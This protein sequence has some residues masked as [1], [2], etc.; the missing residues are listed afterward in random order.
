V[1]IA[2]KLSAY[3][4]GYLHRLPGG[5]GRTS[6]RVA[7]NLHKATVGL[8]VLALML[9]SGD[10]SLAAWLYLVL[11]GTYGLSWLVKDVAF[12]DPAWRGRASIASA[13][14]TFVYPL[15]LYYLAPLVMLT[16]LGA[17][18]PGGWGTTATLPVGVAA[19]A[20]ACY[21]VGAF[22][23]FG[24]DA[25]KHFVLEH[26]RPR[27]LITD[28]FFAATR[29]PNYL[30]E[31]LIYASF[32]LLAQHWLPWAA[33]ALVWI[34]VFVPNMLR[35]ERSMARYPEHAAWVARTG[36]LLPDVRTLL[37]AVPG[38]F[39]SGAR[40]EAPPHEPTPR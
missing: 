16:G 10:R 5:A 24:A 2:E 30:G 31:I 39:R 35:K 12:P 6:P 4:D 21:A 36:F 7:I 1:S 29:N 18:V 8:V 3:A 19:A 13:I 33:C 27:R 38:A 23:H 34:L 26:R 9:R 25:Q 22:L 11:H 32:C 20:V 28:G 17:A 15:G 40:P 14:A 37:G